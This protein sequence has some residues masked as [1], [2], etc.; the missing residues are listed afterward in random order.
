MLTDEQNS[1]QTRKARDEEF[2]T[3][4]SVAPLKTRDVIELWPGSGVGPGSQDSPARLTVT[5]RSQEPFWPD[6]VISGIARPNL[7]AFVPGI[8]GISIDQ[9]PV[10]CR[11]EKPL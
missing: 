5:E 1:L 4:P 2:A 11:A 8:K 3:A 7:T 9:T 6:R 10:V